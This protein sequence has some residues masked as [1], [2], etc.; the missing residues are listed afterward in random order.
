MP[1]K[2]ILCEYPGVHPTARPGNRRACRTTTV[3]AKSARETVQVWSRNAREEL[4]VMGKR[5]QPHAEAISLFGPALGQLFEGTMD[6]FNTHNG[7]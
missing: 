2:E 5:E 6:P 7:F 1:E 3:Q 4:C